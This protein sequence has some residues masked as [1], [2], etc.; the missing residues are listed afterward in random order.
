M[1]TSSSATILIVD[2]EPANLALLSEI[3]QPAYRVRA[4]NGGDGALRVAASEPRPDLILLDVMMPRMDGHQ[5]FERLQETPQTADIPVIFVT[6]LADAV[7]EERG[8]AQG[9]V[10]YITKPIKSSIVLARVRTHLELKNSR[11][12]LRDQNRWL[13]NEVARRLREIELI[14]DVSLSAMAQLAETRDNETGGHILRT[15]AYVAILARRLHAD[16]RF[17]GQLDERQVDLITKATPLHDIGKVGIPDRILL[18]PGPLDEAEFRIM[19]THARIGG[20]AIKHALARAR[21][22]H[23]DLDDETARGSLAFLETARLMATSH[24]ERWDGAGYPDGLS[25]EAIPLAARI[26]AVADV[27]DAMSNKRVYKPAMGLDQVTAHIRRQSAVQFDPDVVEA[28]LAVQ[29]EF[30]DIASRFRDNG[31]AVD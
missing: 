31:S 23:R 20:D 25:G 27:F 9:A 2:D 28:F 16:G 11:D 14:Q 21:R 26:M 6:A 18:K 3:L 12:R 17:A 4:A 24:H 1:N 30:A 29:E 22:V 8:L 5:V 13:E 7:D 15:Q 19:Q 10:D